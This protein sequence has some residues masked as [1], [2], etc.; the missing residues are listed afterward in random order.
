[1]AN[2]ILTAS[3]VA[4]A[5]VAMLAAI[6][7]PI[8]NSPL[9]PKVRRKRTLLAI[10][11]GGEGGVRSDARVEFGAVALLDDEDAAFGELDLFDMRNLQASMSLPPQTSDEV[12][13]AVTLPIL[14]AYCQDKYG[15]DAFAL[16]GGGNFDWN[17]EDDGSVLENNV[18]ISDVCEYQWGP[19]HDEALLG[20]TADDWACVDWDDAQYMIVPVIV[21]A[22][23]I[24][25][26]SEDIA[27]SITSV[28]AVVER[29]RAWYKR[30]MDSGR[31]FHAL[32]PILRL[33]TESSDYWNDLSCLTGSPSDRAEQ[34]VDQES[35]SDRFGYFYEVQAEAQATSLGPAPRNIVAPVFVYTG[36]DSAPFGLGAAAAGP[37]S[38]N[39]PSVAVCPEYSD[40]CGLYSVGHEMG[41]SFGLGHSCEIV[42]EPRCYLGM[43]QNP[44]DDILDAV[45]FG[46][47]QKVLDDSPYFNPKRSKNKKSSKGKSSSA[48]NDEV[49]E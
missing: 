43:M 5:A 26:D 29:V 7:T 32:Q 30:K 13:E 27:R 12:F 49:W 36:P 9:I 41:H 4:V 44:G 37:F 21:V 10:Q 39:P 15:G 33:S 1:M 20:G 3:M 46:K 17:C 34:C 42:A 8:D 45:L 47:E 24:V 19:G 31:T 22:G 18:P 14:N 25:S 28:T 35:P 38:V 6:A 2:S 16:Q 40:T 23:D 11:S 48:E